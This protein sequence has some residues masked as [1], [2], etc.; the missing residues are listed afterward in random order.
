MGPDREG[1]L[2]GYDIEQMATRAH[3]TPVASIY[4]HANH[5]LIQQ[6]ADVERPRKAVSFASTQARQGQAN[7]YLDQH[8][9]QIT[10]DTLMALTR[11]HEGDDLSVCAHVQEGYDVES[12]CACIMAPESRELWALWGNPCQNTYEHFA[13]GSSMMMS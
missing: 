7:A 9:G 6:M 1:V 11:Y 2:R 8:R 4:A 3:V 13:I 5:C 10:V 12:S